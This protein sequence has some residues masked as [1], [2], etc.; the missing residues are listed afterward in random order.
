MRCNRVYGGDAISKPQGKG[1][2]HPNIAMAWDLSAVLLCMGWQHRERRPQTVAT[3]CDVLP[4]K[5]VSLWA[6]RSRERCVGQ[7]QTETEVDQQLG[8]VTPVIPERAQAE[9]LSAERLEKYIKT[10]SRYE[11]GGTLHTNGLGDEVLLLT[12]LLLCGIFGVCVVVSFEF[13]YGPLFNGETICGSR[14]YEYSVCSRCQR[15]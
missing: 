13:F 7:F 9:A 11:T 14:D 5:K 10:N 15:G 6:A 1:V 3:M 4:E 8:P 12:R 2:E